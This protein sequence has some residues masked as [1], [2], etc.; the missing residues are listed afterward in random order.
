MLDWQLPEGIAAGEIAWPAP[1]KIP[2]GTLANYGYEN[3]VL[4][5]VPLKVSDAFKGEQLTIQL[6]AAWL[7]CKKE[8][9]PQEGDFTLSIPAKS[10]KSHCPPNV[11][12]ARRRCRLWWL[13]AQ[14]LFGLKHR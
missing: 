7:V 9:I 3:T 11:L 2:I 5:P 14:T 12:K 6:K 8:C 13:W 4:L 1:K 10:S